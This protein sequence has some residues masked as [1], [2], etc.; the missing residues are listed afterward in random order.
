MKRLNFKSNIDLSIGAGGLSMHQLLD[1]L[2]LKEFDNEILRQYSD[3]AILTELTGKLA[4]STDSYVVKPYFFNGGDIGSLAINGT[5]NDL[6]V[7]GAIPYYIS[8]GFILEEGL[9]LNDL[10]II[11]KSMARAAKNAGVQIVTGDIKVVEKGHGDG[12]YI[13][14]SGIGSIPSDIQIKPEFK[15]GDK[16]IINGSIAN[17]GAAILSKRKGLEF[18]TDI[19]SDC[20]NLNILIQDLLSINPHIRCM[21]DP[22]RGGISAVL[23][24][25]SKY[26][27]LGIN[28]EESKLLI[29]DNVRGLCELLGL[30]PIHIA[31][32]GK[33]IIVCDSKD[34]E[35]ILDKMKNNPLG[36]DSRV[37]GEIQSIN[38]KYVTLTTIF[39]GVRRVEWLSGEQ[40]PRIC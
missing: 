1:E 12:I 30:D 8:V 27:N 15:I 40:L 35:N 16:I 5:I 28:I 22:T 33:V 32:E 39:G 36:I 10:K 23:N 20:A 3:Q 37:I 21:R 6:V 13:N 38:E 25:W 19:V 9:P 29:H 7:G 34:V 2:I 11:V 26:Y 18:S 14:T 4:F 24:E 17:H 31:N